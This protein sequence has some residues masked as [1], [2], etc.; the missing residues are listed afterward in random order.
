MNNQAVVS[1]RPI[2][3]T[4]QSSRDASH[5]CPEHDSDNMSEFDRARLTSKT[6]SMGQD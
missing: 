1:D 3:N 4:E 6:W 2:D 5:Q